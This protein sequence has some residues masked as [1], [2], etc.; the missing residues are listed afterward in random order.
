[1]R[2]VIVEALYLSAENE[3]KQFFLAGNWAMTGKL[4][5]QALE[6]FPSVQQW[7]VTDTGSKNAWIIANCDLRHKILPATP[8]RPRGAD[9]TGPEVMATFM[10]LGPREAS[11]LDP[12]TDLIRQQAASVLELLKQ[13][14]GERW[15]PQKTLAQMRASAPPRGDVKGISHQTS[16]AM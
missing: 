6:R 8:L 4:V 7:D 1:M 2:R 5:R 9:D 13:A 10:P 15:V 11:D 3:I 16:E 14:P 12:V